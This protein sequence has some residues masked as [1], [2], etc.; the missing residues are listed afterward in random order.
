MV[1]PKKELKNTGYEIFIG[2]LSIL[3]IFNLIL[4]YAF[5]QDHYLQYVLYIMNGL[6]SGIFLIDFSYRLYTAP[7][8]SNYFFR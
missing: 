8:R 2:I 1:Q 6:L 3:S 4:L 7:S 5:V